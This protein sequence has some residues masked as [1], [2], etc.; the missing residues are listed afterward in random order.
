MHPP[1]HIKLSILRNELFKLR[2]ACRG[3]RPWPCRQ[4]SQRGEPLVDDPRAPGRGSPLVARGR[5]ERHS[6]ARG[7][8]ALGPES[9]AVEKES[10][11]ARTEALASLRG[12][13]RRAP[14]RL[15]DPPR[16]QARPP[17]APTAVLAFSPSDWPATRRRG[18]RCPI[19][20]SSATYPAS[21]PSPEPASGR[22]PERDRPRPR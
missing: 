16:S 2:P 12:Q 11:G 21:P 7:A 8:P 4:R 22:R 13:P 9:R 17:S 18:R 5:L 10:A 20:T 14:R 3:R 6:I 19:A 15:R 1:A